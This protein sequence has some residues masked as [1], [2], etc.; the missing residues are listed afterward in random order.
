MEIIERPLSPNIPMKESIYMLS[1][2][3]LLL[4]MP[5]KPT[6]LAIS[7]DK[8]T[9]DI[10]LTGPT[11]GTIYPYGVSGSSNAFGGGRFMLA[12]YSQDAALFGIFP[13]GIKGESYSAQ[14]NISGF[15]KP[16]QVAYSLK[17]GDSLP[18]GLSLDTNT[19][20]ISGV[21][22][23]AGIFKL[24]S[25]LPVLSMLVKSSAFLLPEQIVR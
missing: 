19:G 16:L 20:E 11:Y 18:D 8:T 24:Q 14:L 10:I 23:E 7:I 2:Q 17:V 15:Q 12:R 3:E 6:G 13:Q 22:N 25:W 21:L 5:V 9:N 4:P 1:R